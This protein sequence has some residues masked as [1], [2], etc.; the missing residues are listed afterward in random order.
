MNAAKILLLALCCTTL[1]AC[2]RLR[3]PFPKPYV[4]VRGQPYY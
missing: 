4:A 1:A 3:Y 2:V